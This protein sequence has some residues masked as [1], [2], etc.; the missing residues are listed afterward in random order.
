MRQRAHVGAFRAF[1]LKSDQRQIPCR[2]GK[3]EHMHQP[4][5]ALHLLPLARQLVQRHPPLL[6]GRNHGRGVHQVTL[7]LF[8]LR[9]SS[10]LD[11]ECDIALIMN[12]KYHILSKEHVAFNPYQARQYRDWV[13]F[14]IE[15]NRA[16]RAMQD[17]EFQ[18]HAPY[19]AFDPR[20]Q[21][22]QQQ[23]IDDKIIES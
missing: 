3:T 20:G 17:M 1:N 2:Y 18:L 8:H 11:Y 19:F 21:R 10:A 5:L 12:N 15:K 7:H 14:T 4:G 22:V 6:D 13:V 9:G 16:G 23:L